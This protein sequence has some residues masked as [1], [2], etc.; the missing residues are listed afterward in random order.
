MGD[1]QRAVG[2][3]ITVVKEIWNG[4]GKV[5]AKSQDFTHHNAIF[6]V[7]VQVDFSNAQRDFRPL[8][9]ESV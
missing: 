1:L 8:S 9:R 6:I 3:V 7:C 4:L 2:G 5:G